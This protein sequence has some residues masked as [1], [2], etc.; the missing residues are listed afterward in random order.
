MVKFDKNGKQRTSAYIGTYSTECAGDMMDLEQL[1]DTIKTL[2][3]ELKYHGAV[4]KYGHPLRFRLSVKGRKPINKVVNKRTGRLNGY[5]WGGDVIGGLANAAEYD[6]Y[7]H[8]RHYWQET[9]K[10]KIEVELD[11]DRDADEIQSLIEIVER[12]RDKSNVEEDE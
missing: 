6:A 4:T 2:N 1:R 10:I 8:Q 11:T 9:M 7:L 12:I 5:T 3:Q